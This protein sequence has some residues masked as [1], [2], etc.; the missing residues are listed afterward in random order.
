MVGSYPSTIRLPLR[1]TA[2]PTGA[3]TPN[4]NGVATSVAPYV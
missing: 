1:G 2:P 3:T 4:D